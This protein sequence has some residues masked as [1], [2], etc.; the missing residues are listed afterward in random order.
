MGHNF[1]NI[2]LQMVYLQTNVYSQSVS[3][4]ESINDTEFSRSKNLNGFHK[5][6]ANIKLLESINTV[7][8]NAA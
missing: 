5:V 1:L 4:N 2:Y 6:F 3:P 7:L 8:D